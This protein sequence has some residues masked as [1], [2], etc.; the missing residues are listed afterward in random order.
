MLL[1]ILPIPCHL[2]VGLPGSGKTTFA[3]QWIDRCPTYRLVSTDAIRARLYGDASIQGNWPDIEAKVDQQIQTALAGGFPIIYD[4]TNAKRAWRLSFLQRVRQIS[5]QTPWVAWIFNTSN[6]VCQQRNRQRNRVVPP[7]VIEALGTDLDRFPPH[8]SEGFLAVRSVPLTPRGDY[9]FATLFYPLDRLY[10]QRNQRLK[11]TRHLIW[12]RYARLVDF[13]RLMYLLSWLLQHPQA[14][15]ACPEL[16]ADL[17]AR[18]HGTIYGN[19]NAL[20]DDLQWLNE[21]SFFAANTNAPVAIAPIDRNLPPT[22]LPH[23][24][25]TLNPRTITK[26]LRIPN[27][28]RRV[29]NANLC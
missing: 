26:S 6:A 12:H 3:R 19:A 14:E 13:E 11:Y 4:A 24:R 9:N 5:P 23:P 25:Q 7:S 17:L 28:L 16:L 8:V 15:T 2:L 27:K 1:P 10:P 20:T 29:R 18:T 22:D 21:N